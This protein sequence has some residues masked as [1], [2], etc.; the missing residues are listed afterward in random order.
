MRAKGQ[1]FWGGGG[2]KAYMSSGPELQKEKKEE[3]GH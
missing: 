3:W 2:L 1:S